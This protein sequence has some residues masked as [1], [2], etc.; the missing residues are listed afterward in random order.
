[1]ERQFRKV[2]HTHDMYTG[3][4]Y[5]FMCSRCSTVYNKEYIQ[6]IYAHYTNNVQDYYNY[7]NYK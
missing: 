4:V 1:M 5:Y 6:P 2:S 7:N 3:D